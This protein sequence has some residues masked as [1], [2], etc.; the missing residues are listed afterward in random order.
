[1]MDLGD[2]GEDMMQR[3][4]EAGRQCSLAIY[5]VFAQNNKNETRIPPNI[6]VDYKMFPNNSLNHQAIGMLA[7]VR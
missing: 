1:M 4:R 2:A 6:L 7:A 5:S 3:I